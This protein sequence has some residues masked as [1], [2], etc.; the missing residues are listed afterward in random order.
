MIIDIKTKKDRE[1]VALE[2]RSEIFAPEM[3]LEYFH[4]GRSTPLRYR[5]KDILRKIKMC[6][7]LLQSSLQNRLLPSGVSE[8]IA[9]VK[10]S[11][12]SKET[13]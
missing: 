11:A 8:V 7:V 3:R 12:R 2:Y 9:P 4:A 10:K 6:E 1:Q 5:R 13:P